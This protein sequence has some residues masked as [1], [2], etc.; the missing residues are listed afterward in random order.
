MFNFLKKYFP[1][2]NWILVKIISIDML[3]DSR[4]ETFYF[5]LFESNKGNRK[6]K[7]AC[8][9][10]LNYIEYVANQVPIYHEKICR[11]ESGR[12]DPDIPRW[13]Q[14]PEEDTV[15]VLKGNI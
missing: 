9:M 6:V 4:E 12:L 14:I 13:D 5:R 7:F 3:I 10:S 15:N 1:K 2:E 8:T 11:W